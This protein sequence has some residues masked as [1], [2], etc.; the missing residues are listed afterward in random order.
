[1]W[2]NQLCMLSASDLIHKNLLLERDRQRVV[3]ACALVCACEGTCVGVR[4]MGG[5]MFSWDSIT[6]TFLDSKQGKS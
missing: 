1:M 6:V 2:F 4:C 5:R 3:W